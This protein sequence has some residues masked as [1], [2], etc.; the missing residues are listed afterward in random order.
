ML[1]NVREMTSGEYDKGGSM[2]LGRWNSTCG[3]CSS[4]MAGRRGG[5]LGWRC[6]K[7]LKPPETAEGGVGR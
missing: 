6:V 4:K 2:R 1:G 3:K 7:D 5:D